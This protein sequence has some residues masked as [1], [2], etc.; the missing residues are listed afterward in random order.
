MKRHPEGTE[1]LID[2]REQRRKDREARILNDPKIMQSIRR[3]QR[4]KEVSDHQPASPRR[5]VA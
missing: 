5:Q 4:K 2:T 3:D 1:K